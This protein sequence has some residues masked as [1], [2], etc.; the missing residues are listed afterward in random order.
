MRIASFNIRF[1]NPADGRHDWNG[2]RQVAADLVNEFGP[3]ILG[4]QEG[5]QPQILDFDS[6]LG[7]V[8][9]YQE[10]RNWIEE[11]VP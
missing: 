3:T 8:E 5:R 1:D 2:R 4:T 11:N 7:S 6:L 10:H 9:L